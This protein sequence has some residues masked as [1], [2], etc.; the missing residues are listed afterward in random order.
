MQEQNSS[1]ARY[2]NSDLSI[3]L[4][5]DPLADKYP[6]LSPYTYCADNPVKLVD[7]DG[8]EVYFVGNDND[9]AVWQL[10]NY[11]SLKLSINDDGKLEYAGCAKTK[12]DE[13]LIEAIEDKNISVYITTDKSNSFGGIASE[14]GGAYMG[15]FFENGKV[16]ADQ[17]ICPSMLEKF[18]KSVGDSK[19]GLTMVHELAES[20]YGGKIALERQQTSPHEGLPGS[21]YNEAHF[22]ANQVAIG[23]RGKVYFKV[24][25]NNLYCPRTKNGYLEY[26]EGHFSLN[27]PIGWKRMTNKNGM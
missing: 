13:M 19:P 3:W 10:Q 14:M 11:T 2:Y 9:R 24:N 17:Y 7:E 4:S 25:I 8:K 26:S 6:N 23:N 27:I 12:I 16:C 20:Y 22:M 18:D 21:T 1:S 5:D 15:N